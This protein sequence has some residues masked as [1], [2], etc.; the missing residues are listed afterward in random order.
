MEKERDLA[1]RM[2]DQEYEIVVISPNKIVHILRNEGVQFGETGITLC[3]QKF[4][5]DGKSPKRWELFED[6]YFNELDPGF[7][8]KC[9]ELEIKRMKSEILKEAERNK[10]N[11]ERIP[12]SRENLNKIAKV[13]KDHKDCKLSIHLHGD[14]KDEFDAAG[15]Y[16]ETCKYEI[17]FAAIKDFDIDPTILFE[18]KDN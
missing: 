10:D 13:F 1:E 16:C 14:S 4:V 3:N 7:C 18:V 11:I 5:D 9:R 12:I 8:K 17:L 6:F 2:R 15:L